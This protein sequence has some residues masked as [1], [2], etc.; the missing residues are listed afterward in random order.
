MKRNLFLCLFC[1]YLSGS[2]AQ[3]CF[4]KS[5]T[6]PR[7]GDKINKQEIRYLPPGESGT[8]KVWQFDRL[9]PVDEQYE[10]AYTGNDSLLMGTEHRT[11]Y[12]YRVVGD[13]LW[14]TVV[15]NISTYQKAIYPELLAVY[16][17]QLGSHFESYFGYTGEYQHAYGMELLGKTTVSV[18]AAGILIIAGDTVPDVLRIHTKRRFVQDLNLS[19]E[20]VMAEDSAWWLRRFTP[21]SISYRISTD[22][23]VTQTDTYSWYASG[24]RYPVLETVEN[25]LIRYGVSIPHFQTAFYYPP[26]DQYYTLNEDAENRQKR[27]EPLAQRQSGENASRNGSFSLEDAMGKCKFYQENNNL[28]VEYMLNTSCEVEIALYT[29]RGELLAIYPKKALRPGQYRESIAIDSLLSERYV[30]RLIVNGKVYGEK[31]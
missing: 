8:G 19:N 15:E 6:L 9:T 10:L 22:T 14:K 4:H 31:I 23:L 1:L 13:S 25:T 27:E 3:T 7:V 26:V 2:H 5:T 18:D 16:P 24:Y 28:V 17:M 20:S 29:V 21:D 30:L 12:T 11:R